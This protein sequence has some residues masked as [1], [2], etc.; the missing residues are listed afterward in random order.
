M[1]MGMVTLQCE[2]VTLP[3]WNCHTSDMEHVDNGL[4]LSQCWGRC[5]CNGHLHPS[6]IA[7]LK[8]EPKA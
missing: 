4:V 1:V 3:M 2:M 7:E 5:I 6:L 8:M